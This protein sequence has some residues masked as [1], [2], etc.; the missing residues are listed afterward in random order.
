VLPGADRP[1]LTALDRLDGG[2]RPHPDDEAAYDDDGDP[3]CEDA[4][5][6][7]PPPW[8][9]PAGDEEDQ[10]RAREALEAGFTH[11]YG[12]TGTGFSAGGPLDEMLPGADLAWHAG[13]ARQRGLGA[14][15]DDELTGALG[16]TRKL[17]S[18]AAGFEL[19]LVAELDARR[20]GPDGREGEH[21]AEELAAALTLTARSSSVLLELW[22][23][24]ERLPQ[25][26][27]LLAAGVIDRAR[28]ARSTW[29]CPPPP[30]S[31]WPTPPARSPGSAPTTP[32]PAATSP[33]PSPTPTPPPAG[34]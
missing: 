20:A 11:R 23:Q 25:T 22:R 21:V 6:G 26:A 15:S 28:A 19:A 12:G 13:Q 1:A 24:L 27:A 30:G 2:W 10:P 7:S 31:A 8:A 29:S 17:C 3:G 4:D 18:W 5:L 14:L 9:E 32:P 33:P 34:A 16:G